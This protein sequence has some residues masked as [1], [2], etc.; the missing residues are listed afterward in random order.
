MRILLL[1]F[2][3][4]ACLQ[5]NLKGQVAPRSSDFVTTENRQRMERY[6]KDTTI[7]LALL[8]SP[9]KLVESQWKSAFWAMELLSERNEKNESLIRQVLLRYDRYSESFRRALL[10][11]VYAL[12]PS[13]FEWEINRIISKESNPKRFAICLAYLKRSAQTDAQRQA[14]FK[15]IERAFPEYK[16]DP[17]LLSA[18]RHLQNQGTTLP[19]FRSLQNHFKGQKVVYSFQRPNRD[20]AG[21]AIVQDTSG[22]ISVDPQG[23]IQTFEQFGRSASNLPY[24]LTNGNTPQGL[25]WIEDTATSENLFIGPTPNLQSRLPY[26]TSYIHFSQGIDSSTWSLPLYH[27][28]LPAAWRIPAMEE[29]YYAGKAGRSEII[30]HG[31]CIDP[32]YY[33]RDVY[34]PFTPSM[35]CLTGKEIWNAN[36]TLQYSA[37][38]GLVNTWLKA[39]TARS[40]YL[41]VIELEDRKAPI[42]TKDIVA[43]M[44]R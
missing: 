27:Q 37:Q 32:N 36:G 41:I 1:L 25:Y 17:I 10:E 23:A 30:A 7:G 26:E 8:Q 44:A 33:Q 43:F 5:P 4:C 24:F 40:G 2:F 6:L 22:Q 18:H 9:D 12:Y 42:Q 16:Q 38:L 15:Q 20:Y 14:L 19:A 39:G 11:L 13:Q 31:T 28:L 29:S 35:G 34:F 21:M 3:A